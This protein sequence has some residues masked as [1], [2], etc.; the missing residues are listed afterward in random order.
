MFFYTESIENLNKKTPSEK[1]NILNENYFKENQI[2]NSET[3]PQGSVFNLK[4]LSRQLNELNNMIY[5]CSAKLKRL[6]N[7]SNNSTRIKSGK[8]VI[9]LK[10][11]NS[12]RAGSGISYI[13]SF[14]SYDPKKSEK[15]I[16]SSSKNKL[17][18]VMTIVSDYIPTSPST[19]NSKNQVCVLSKDNQTYLPNTKFYPLINYDQ[20]YNILKRESENIKKEEFLNDFKKKKLEE[21]RQFNQNNKLVRHNIVILRDKIKEENLQKRKVIDSEKKLVKFSIEE[22]KTINFEKLQKKL[23]TQKMQ[24]NNVVENKLKIL[25]NIKSKI[26]IESRSLINK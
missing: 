12:S 15:Q 20:N 23:E 14:K 1:E 8:S 21:A 25:N 13:K 24:N 17:P 5:T 18:E 3:I 10:L 4:K 7:E 16:H 6:E 11:S 22:L 2:V 19:I 9:T 26:T